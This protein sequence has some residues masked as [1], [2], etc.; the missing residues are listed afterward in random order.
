[1]RTQKSEFLNMKKK[2]LGETFCILNKKSYAN[3]NTFLDVYNILQALKLK[4]LFL[5]FF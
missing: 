3:Q 4:L 1:M 5:V 2:K